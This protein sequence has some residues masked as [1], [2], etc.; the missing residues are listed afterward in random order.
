MVIAPDHQL[1]LIDRFYNDM[2]NRFDTTVVP[3]ILLPE[4]RFRGS[5]GQEKVGWSEFRDYVEFVQAF[6]PDFH[7]TVEETITQDDRTFARL[8]YTG[9]HR[10]EVFGLEPTGRRF[11]SGGAAVFRF[12]DELISDVWVLGDIWGLVAQLRGE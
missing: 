7:N 6:A 3:E 12:S 5:L 2:W 8:T 10:G 1:H 9:T 4:I 11:T